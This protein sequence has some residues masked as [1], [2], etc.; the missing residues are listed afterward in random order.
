MLSIQGGSLNWR[1]FMLKYETS[2]G[3]I[4]LKKSSIG[5]WKVLLV[6]HGKGHWAFPKGHRFPNEEKKA[7]AE[8][9]LKEETNLIISHYLNLPEL[10]EEYFFQ[11]QSIL[12]KKKVFYWTALVKGRV[13]VQKD[14]IS[15][16]R[17]LT[18]DEA[19]LLATFAE[20][21]KICQQLQYLLN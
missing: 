11:R 10:Q 12:I 13:K 9:E 17:W 4:P 8:R 1:F 15:D 21:K 5:L 19:S 2:F 18:F 6:L 7:A 3:I 16:F 20:T 14:E